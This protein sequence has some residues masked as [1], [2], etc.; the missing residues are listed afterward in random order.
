MVERLGIPASQAVMA[1]IKSE[2]TLG[3]CCGSWRQ[4]GG[5]IG[6]LA[7]TSP[8]RV[9]PALDL[10]LCHDKCMRWFDVEGRTPYIKSCVC[11]CKP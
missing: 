10:S 5:G 1:L 2:S 3:Y 7:A 9:A 4:D 11:A 8:S 6:T